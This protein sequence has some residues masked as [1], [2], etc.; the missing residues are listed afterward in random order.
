MHP[1]GELCFRASVCSPERG[2]WQSATV[3]S[4]LE[5]PGNAP[6]PWKAAWVVAAIVR[7]WVLSR[8]I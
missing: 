5:V 2:F 6:E 3:A 1:S 8:L 4:A 7:S